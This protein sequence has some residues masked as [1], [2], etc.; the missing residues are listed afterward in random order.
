MTITGHVD[1]IKIE[2][3]YYM[4][5][6][7]NSSNQ[8]ECYLALGT[9]YGYFL[10][11]LKPNI[12]CKFKSLEDCDKALRQGKFQVENQP[13]KEILKNETVIETKSF[14]LN[15]NNINDF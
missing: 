12:K 8:I 11:E 6:V 7:D 1:I 2:D 15:L 4:K 13:E 10:T 3:G 5:I 14:K 9:I